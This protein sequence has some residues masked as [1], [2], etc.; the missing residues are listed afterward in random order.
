MRNTQYWLIRFLMIDLDTKQLRSF[1][2]LAVERSFSEAARQL[3]CSQAT[4]SVRIQKLEETFGVRL[5]DRGPHEV[6][7]TA[8][9]R[10]LLPD[11]RA[12]VDMQ[13]RMYE[14]TQ[15]RRVIG[16]I[17]I[18]IAESY[19]AS[20]LPGLLKYMQQNYA[21][22]ELDITCRPSW[23]LQQLIEARTLDLAVVTLPEESQSAVVLRRPQL[24][25][26]AAPG[27]GAR[28]LDAGTRRLASEQ[29]LLPDRGSRCAQEPRHRLSRGAVQR[30]FASHS[31]RSR[32]RNR[33][34]R[35]GRRNRAQDIERD[36]CIF[37]LAA[38]GQGL[39]P[40]ARKAGFAVGG[41]GGGQAR[42]HTRIPGT[43]DA[44]RLTGRS[45]PSGI[46]TRARAPSSAPACPVGGPD[47]RVA[48]R[49]PRGRLCRLDR[50]P[51]PESATRAI[52]PTAIRS[53]SCGERGAS[54]PSL[55]PDA[56]EAAL[57]FENGMVPTRYPTRFGPQAVT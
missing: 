30:R 53:N 55:M 23:R 17:R 31:V 35:H 12:L 46:S 42:I 10:D 33:R 39:H 1:L 8:E 34:Y 40:V 9:G 14:R 29:M 19:E 44:A 47:R 28:S 7:L 51:A 21:A 48:G 2:C 50:H 3:G 36:V 56:L 24:H 22:A 5:F 18:G 43:D 41:A 27:A 4:M 13:D 54:V 32:S 37:S 57:K 20:L 15:T 26:V 6:K 49:R 45:A 38:S 11:I 16:Q 52:A 25:W